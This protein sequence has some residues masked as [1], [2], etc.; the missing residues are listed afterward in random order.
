MNYFEYM[1]AFAEGL[2][3]IA[4]PCILPVLPLVLASSADGGKKRPFGIIIGF[5]LAFSLFALLARQLITTLGIS[6]DLVKN[7]SLFLLLLFGL[8]L[9]SARLSERFTTL[10]Q[11]LAGKGMQA[12]QVRGE[13]LMSGIII[14][15]LIGLVWTPCA[16]PIIAAV[17]VQVIVQKTQ[18]SSFMVLAAFALG[19]GIPM[20]VIAMMGRK[21]MAKLGFFTHH[22]EAIRKIFGIAIIL[23]ALVLYTGYDISSVFGY[24]NTTNMQQALEKPYPAPAITGIEQWINSPPLDMASLKGKVVLVDFW[25]YSCINCVRTLPHIKEWNEKYK[26]KGLVII[27]VHSP[28]FEFEKNPDNVREAVKKQGIKYAVALDNHLSTW[29]NFT[30]RY[31]PAHYLI[32]KEGQVVYTHFG[33]GN[34]DITEQTIRFLL[35]LASDSSAT[36]TSPISSDNQT[37]ETY[38]GYAR[39]QHFAGETVPLHDAIMDYHFPAILPLHH[40]ALEGKWKM[41]AERLITQDKNA[42]LQFH[43]SAKKAYLVMG[44]STD[45]PLAASISLNGKAMKPIAVSRHT[46]YELVNQEHAK[47]GQLQITAD[48]AGLEVYAFTFGE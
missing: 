15:S 3:I 11:K 22:S 31:W 14:G 38:L 24:E 39:E 21:I 16:G 45:T 17:L 27:G 35:G 9:L 37:P 25:T 23:S 47:E 26:D 29:Q 36:T 20:V 48:H 32:N 19:A 30:N 28:E 4:S 42:A 41:E 44:N 18:F 8:T 1:A 43:F 2:A 5:V 6:P 7:V 46:L 10:T 34:Y 12:S 33:E 40:W 13:G